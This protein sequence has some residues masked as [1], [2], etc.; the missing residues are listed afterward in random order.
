MEFLEN[1]KTG[2]VKAKKLNDENIQNN[3]LA[4]QFNNH[5]MGNLDHQIQ[6]SKDAMNFA[7]NQTSQQQSLT[8]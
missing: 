6:Y 2:F 7:Q 3:N 5:P 8:A 1:A 4:E